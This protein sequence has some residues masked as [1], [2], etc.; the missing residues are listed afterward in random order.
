MIRKCTHLECFRVFPDPAPVFVVEKRVEEDEV[1]ILVRLQRVLVL[2]LREA[3]IY[4]VD[5]AKVRDN[6]NMKWLPSIH[7]YVRYG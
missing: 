7:R 4:A 6:L 3:V 2:V 5:T 1:E